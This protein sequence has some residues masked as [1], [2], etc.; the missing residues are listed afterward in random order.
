[1]SLLICKWT[2]YT[3]NWPPKQFSAL[4]MLNNLCILEVMTSAEFLRAT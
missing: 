4:F 3:L 2:P 1:M